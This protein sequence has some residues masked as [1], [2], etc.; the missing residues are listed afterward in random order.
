MNIKSAFLI[1]TI[2]ALIFLSGCSY[3]KSLFPDKE[4]DYQYTT[5]IPLLI[6]PQD[7]K[8]SQIPGLTS[9]TP[10]ISTNL[11]LPTEE[12]DN[13]ALTTQ[14][15]PANTDLPVNE[16]EAIE[17]LIAL[18][19]IKLNDDGYSLRINSPFIKAWR[20]VNKSLSRKSIEVTDRNQEKKLFTIKYEPE[21]QPL[22]DDSYWSDLTFMISGVHDNEKTYLIKLDENND[23][24]D[25]TIIDEDHKLLSDDASNKLLTLLENTIKEDLATK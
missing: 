2:T 16:P 1:I 21:E 18:E 24:T 7:L 14:Q 8:N 25:I 3:I 11:D 17:A 23:Y 12:S 15:S 20:I 5:E 13:G 6:L 19:R 9:S 10:I 4:K 22:Q